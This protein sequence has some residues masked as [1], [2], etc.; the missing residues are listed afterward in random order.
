MKR[1]KRRNIF[2]LLVDLVSDILALVESAGGCCL[3]TAATFSSFSI[4]EWR[5]YSTFM[6]WSLTL[7]IFKVKGHKIKYEMAA[8][9]GGLCVVCGRAH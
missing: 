6:F 4:M 2:S 9:A 8:R 7:T 1:R 5:S 3:V